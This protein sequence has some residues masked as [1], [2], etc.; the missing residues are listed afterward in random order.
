METCDV[1]HSLTAINF[2]NVKV[3]LLWPN[4]SYIKQNGAYSLT[5]EE[6]SPSTSDPC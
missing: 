5:A 6:A 3:A 4:Y 1:V 2:T